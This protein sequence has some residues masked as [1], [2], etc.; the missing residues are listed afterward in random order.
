[1]PGSCPLPTATSSPTW[2]KADTCRSPLRT[3][4]RLS[5][6][7][8]LAV[9]LRPVTLDDI[10]ILERQVVNDGTDLNWSGFRSRASL[11]SRIQDDGYLTATEGWLMVEVPDGP[12]VGSVGYSATDWARPPYSRAWRIG[13]ALVPEW[14][15]KGIGTAAQRALCDYLFTTT[16]VSRIE[17]VTSTT[18]VPEQRALMTVGFTHEGT[19][20]EAAF[21]LGAV[22]DVMMF[23]LLRR[24]WEAAKH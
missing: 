21:H 13:I 10:A 22:H 23:S 12:T 14:R 6:V 2:S 11:V 9:E 16:A 20:R 18:N 8:A 3:A 4:V 24:E 1:M 15:G 19:L 7:S 5:L 17:A